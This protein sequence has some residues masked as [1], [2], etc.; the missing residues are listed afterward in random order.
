MTH[1]NVQ[2]GKELIWPE[3]KDFAF[4]IIDDTDAGTLK[5]TEAVYDLLYENGLF[6]TKTVWAFPSR[7]HFLG[8][9][10]ADRRYKE[11]ICDLCIKGYEIASHGPGSGDFT[12]DETIES[13]HIIERLFGNYPRI[14]INHASNK[15]NL[16]WAQKRFNRLIGLLFLFIKKLKREEIAISY[17]DDPESPYYWGDHAKE[18]VQ[19]MRNHV[20]TGLDLFKYEH[21]TP[22]RE[23]SKDDCSNFW[24]SSSDGF[25]CKTFNRLLEPENVDELVENHGCAIVYTHFGYGFVENGKLDDT[26]KERIEYLSNKNGWFVPAGELLDYL[27]ENKIEDAYLNGLQKFTLDAKWFFTR[28]IRKILLR[29]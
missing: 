1:V 3:N 18:K 21:H 19:Y 14:F 28:I 23:R 7:D 25:D 29:V 17:G 6:T 9:S 13:L 10:L 27:L 16:Y 4:T 20:F 24:F 5:N 12:R 2:G 15:G 8:E 26:F 11:F 22:Y